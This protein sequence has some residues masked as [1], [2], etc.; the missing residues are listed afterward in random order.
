MTSQSQL[1][2]IIGNA[3]SFI[4]ENSNLVKGIYKHVSYNDEP[5]LYGYSVSFKNTVGTPEGEADAGGLSFN[6]KRA[7]MR[8]LGEAIERFSLGQ[9]NEKQFIYKTFHDLVKLHK[10][11]L[12]P[13]TL[14]L[15][16]HK[17][18]YA[19]DMES[20]KFHWVEGRYLSSHKKVLVPAQIVYTPYVYQSSELMLS[21]SISTGAAAG[22]SLSEA[23]YRG[24]CEVVERDSFMISY[25]NKIPSPHINLTSM[26]ER[27][28]PNIVEI[29][30]RYN[31]ELIV[32]DLTTN[33]QIPA[34]AAII[35]DR[36]GVGPA[37]SV[38]L[39][40]GFNSSDAIIGAIEEA[41]MVR[42]YT[43]GK[44]SYK[45]NI[46]KIN[47]ITTIE[48]R[49]QFWSSIR[50]IKKLDFWLNSK[51]YKNESTRARKSSEDYLKRA[52]TLLDKRGIDIIYVDITDKLVKKY[53]FTVVKVIIPKLQ[54][55]YLDERYPY[56]Q[57]D[58]IYNT[59]VEMGYY[60]KPKQRNLLNTTPHPFL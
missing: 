2:T 4:F 6:Q 16:P 18:N 41:Q 17:N 45:T 48:E 25:L 57:K 21:F 30:R 13:K 59:P 38:G 8:A 51:T 29:Y 40:A 47:E 22:T 33:I 14:I 43:R 31:L 24:I 58:R 55:L 54:P 49:A 53:G 10:S 39:K 32:L 35:L 52:V 1:D 27:L 19:R 34:F 3:L 37:V 23:L 50:M 46:N 26:K 36:T 12:D 11:A 9:N 15:Y 5:K 56:I 44:I 7:L 20:S 60:Q 42:F 28:L